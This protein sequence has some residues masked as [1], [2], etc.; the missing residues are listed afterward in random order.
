MKITNEYKKIVQIFGQDA[1]W[2]VPADWHTPTKFYPRGTFGVQTMKSTDKNSAFIIGDF[3]YKP[4]AYPLEWAVDGKKVFYVH[5]PL[6]ITHLAVREKKKIKTEVW[7]VDDPL[8]WFAAKKYLDALP[9]GNL[10]VAGLGLGLVLLH[11]LER[12]DF[13]KITV[14]ERN[15]NIAHYVKSW[16]PEDERVEIVVDDYYE[17][18]P[19][20][21]H[22]IE[23]GRSSPVDS[24]YWDLARGSSSDPSVKKSWE[25]A[26]FKTNYYLD[27]SVQVYH[28]FRVDGLLAI[29]GKNENNA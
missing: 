1:I 23:R 28:G 18:L 5:E 6:T 22:D 24:V 13:T 7:M 20:L 27:G 19:K 16:L 3:V 11:A 9:G 15:Q 17:Y 14:V 25:I 12:T 2:D 10:L 29:G 4:G 26:M 8:H 21:A